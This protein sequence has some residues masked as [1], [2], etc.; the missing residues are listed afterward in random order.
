MT[1]VTGR[2]EEFEDSGWQPSAPKMTLVELLALANSGYP[3][4]AM[5]GYYDAETGAEKDEGG[6]T[7]ALFVVRE[8]RATFDADAGRDAQLTEA[9]RVVKRGIEDLQATLVALEDPE[10]G[11]V[12]PLPA[13]LPA[14]QAGPER[15]AI[16]ASAATLYRE[17]ADGLRDAVE[18]V[19]L[20]EAGIPDDYA[21]LVVLLEKI[22]AADPETE[23][24]AGPVAAIREH[25]LHGW[26]VKPEPE[27]LP[28]HFTSREL[29]TMLH[30]LRMYQEHS[31]NSA[32]AVGL[33]EH[34]ADCEPL[35][36]EEID[37][38]CESINQAPTTA[39]HETI[40]PGMVVG[41]DAGP[42]GGAL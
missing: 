25:G 23:P 12:A 34:F 32:C 6:D 39:I 3:D 13:G 42:V 35:T 16:P 9:R 37:T 30:A 21:W 20:T 36:N 26:N 11:N 19:R 7:L 22:A 8:I 18:E 17:L 40:T 33:C 10:K 2:R 28:P 24:A 41:L 4:G 14:S 27:S 15:G 38:L 31:E 5:D 29:A 1:K